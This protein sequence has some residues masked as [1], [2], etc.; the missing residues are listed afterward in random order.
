MP[1][2]KRTKRLV[3]RDDRDNDVKEDTNHQSSKQWIWKKD[4]IN[5]KRR[6]IQTSR[7]K[8]TIADQLDRNFGKLDILN[9]VL[10]FL[11][12]LN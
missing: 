7:L 5:Q 12:S 6:T 3:T 1:V 4:V 11:F 2:R 10:L 9:T 8:P